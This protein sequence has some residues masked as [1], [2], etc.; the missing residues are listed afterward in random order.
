MRAELAETLSGLLDWVPDPASAGLLVTGVEIDFPLEI[1]PAVRQG[2]LV[3]HASA[4]HS[5][6]KAGVLPDVHLARLV[7][8]LVETAE[9]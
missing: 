1:A 8:E 6:W 2:R 5:R 7:V 9:A 4:P 3:F